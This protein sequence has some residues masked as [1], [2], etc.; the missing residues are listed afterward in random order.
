MITLIPFP[1][2]RRLRRGK[3]VKTIKVIKGIGPVRTIP[4][5]T[6]TFW[7]FETGFP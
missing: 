2:M 6:T 4:C 3:G 5:P 1:K 7:S